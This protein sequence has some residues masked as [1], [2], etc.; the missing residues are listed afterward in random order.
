[1]SSK[2]P[3]AVT[4]LPKPVVDR[5]RRYAEE[6]RVLHASYEHNC[7]RLLAMADWQLPVVLL[8]S[9]RGKFTELHSAAL[10]E[11]TRA[12]RRHR[13]KSRNTFEAS[14]KPYVAAADVEKV[15]VREIN[16]LLSD[17]RLILR[18]TLGA[19]S[20]KRLYPK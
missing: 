3:T 8:L 19:A 20:F 14:P 7:C 5:I 11:W 6:G 10:T 13:S 18:E 9:T 4:R 2:A 16:A 12:A 17:E 1:M 15:Y